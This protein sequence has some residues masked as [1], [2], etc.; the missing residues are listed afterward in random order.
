MTYATDMEVKYEGW[1]VQKASF[2]DGVASFQ[3]HEKLFLLCKSDGHKNC[4][5]HSTK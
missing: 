4:E 2:I 3:T 5:G 1:D